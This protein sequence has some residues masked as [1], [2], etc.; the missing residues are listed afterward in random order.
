MLFDLIEIH[1]PVFF[2][3]GLCF[4]FQLERMQ[5]N[6]A[7]LFPVVLLNDKQKKPLVFPNNETREVSRSRLFFAYV[8]TRN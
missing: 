3:A 5:K 7:A 4:V 8:F 6:L 2:N 1:S